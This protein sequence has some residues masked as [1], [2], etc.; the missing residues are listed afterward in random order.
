MPGIPAV[1]DGDG[2]ASRSEQARDVARWLDS[3]AA[4][5]GMESAL[6]AISRLPPVRYDDA[7]WRRIESLLALLPT[8]AA[9]LATVFASAG[10]F[11]FPQGTLAALGALG[12]GDEPGD[13]LLRL[14]LAVDHILVDEFQDTSFAHLELLSRLT[15]GWTDD[16]GRTLFAVGDPMQSIYGFRGAEVRAFVEAQASGRVEGVAVET[17]RLRRNFRSQA[18][19]VAWTNATFAG[20]LG[21]VSDM[22]RGRVA[23]SPAEAVKPRSAHEPCTVD[24]PRDAGEE[25]AHVV[26]RVREAL[27]SDGDIAVLVRSR[28]H[29]ARIL[30][31]LRA[32]GIAY[33]A[34]EL[35]VLAERPA[36][37]DAVAL[38]HALIQPDDRLAWL[39][40]LRAPWCGLDLADLHAVQRAAQAAG[41]SLEAIVRAPP[42]QIGAD[43]RARLARVAAAVARAHADVPRATLAERVRDA[44]LALRGPATLD[45]PLDLAA[46]DDVVALVEAHERAGDIDDWNALLQRIDEERLSPRPGERA[47]VQV[48]TMHK[49]KGL[50]FDA[51]I[52]PGVSSGRSRN[53]APL[54]RWRVRREGLLVGLAKPQGGE[55]DGVY[56]YLKAIADEEER[57]ELARLAYVACTRAKG[58]LALIATVRARE[59]A[60]SG[61]LEWA[62]PSDG[63][64]F[65]LL[66]APGFDALAPPEAL[67][68]AEEGGA[69]VPWIERLPVEWE[70]PAPPSSLVQRV[71]LKA[72]EEAVPFEW[73][74]ER[75]RRL[76]VVVHRALARIAAEGLDAW[77]PDTLASRLSRW[78]AELVAEGAL[79]SDAAAEAADVRDTLSAVLR[80]ARG[81]WLFAPSHL[82]ARSEW[83]IA[84]LD[85][86]AIV[87]VVLDRTFVADGERW[88]VDFKTGTH[89]GADPAG[90]LDG[91]VE[92]YRPQLERY[93]RI[94]A[95]LDPAHRIRLALYHPRVPGGWRELA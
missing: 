62:P 19:L 43:G 93:A 13:L 76:G 89:E 85:E 4:V 46:V 63:S 80:D 27:A 44:W 31:A 38:A 75:A 65:G 71:T 74:H 83:A 51:V 10:E 53:D 18:G 91:E 79:P 67:D 60:K 87:H 57:A 32:A 8:L 35:D 2:K 26:A 30:P 16:D 72:V 21:D 50:E 55:H 41:R 78:G 70:A 95:A 68:D 81:R 73:V 52:L 77:H 28:A 22:A 86:G 11:D 56:A 64:L 15:A 40:V 6:V 36:V 45:D 7:G 54:L 90:F 59:N 12:T 84:G 3:L 48:M 14:D 1:G 34:V 23:F 58:R 5:P 29:L 20:V 17:L 94:V 39:A 69:A 33:D 9:R 92:R 25:A 24:F 42:P 61:A 49:A 66:G 88:I 37:R 82:E 47:R